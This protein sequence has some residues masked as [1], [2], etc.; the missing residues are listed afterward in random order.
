MNRKEKDR[1]TRK[2]VKNLEK[3][4]QFMQEQQTQ[5]LAFLQQ[6]ASL[7]KAKVGKK[8]K[9]PS[10]DATVQQQNNDDNSAILQSDDNESKEN[11]NSPFNSSDDGSE[12]EQFD[13]QREDSPDEKEPKGNRSAEVELEKRKLEA[14]AEVARKMKK[15]KKRAEE[16]EFS[17]TDEDMSE[18][19]GESESEKTIMSPTGK[20]RTAL[21]GREQTLQVQIAAG[22][23]QNFHPF[24]KGV[25]LTIQKISEL[26]EKVGRLQGQTLS[27]NQRR[28]LFPI[29]LQESM[30]SRV[31]EWLRKDKPEM[32]NILKHRAPEHLFRLKHDTFFRLL[33]ACYQPPGL[34]EASEVEYQLELEIAALPLELFGEE[35]NELDKF[36]MAMKEIG[37]SHGLKDGKDLFDMFTE[38]KAKTLLKGLSD[39]FKTDS[40]DDNQ[41]YQKLYR[42]L[43]G[44]DRPKNLESWTERALD[45]YSTCCDDIAKGNSWRTKHRQG[46]TSDAGGKQAKQ[47]NP[48]QPRKGDGNTKRSDSSDNPQPVRENC[49]I[50]N[51]HH[52]LTGGCFKKGHPD[53][54]LSRL[55]FF[56]TEK[57][58]AYQT[59]GK[60]V[61]IWGKKLSRDLKSL[62][63][64]PSQTK[65][66]VSTIS[67]VQTL[68][69]S[70]IDVDILPTSVIERTRGHLLHTMAAMP[71]AQDLKAKIQAIP[72]KLAIAQTVA[73]KRQ[74]S[75]EAE[76]VDINS[77]LLKF[78]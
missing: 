47:P 66:Q 69:T 75:V 51:G 54:N 43:T 11:Q 50:C 64:D 26:Q 14:D 60:S 4:L 21:K 20:T 36:V 8:A 28:A 56:D 35:R 5:L 72:S 67:S 63:D 59:L 16:L 61:L 42:A 41:L 68:P 71:V 38:K 13:V 30:I 40:K 74:V 76:L 49:R 31:K 6:S 70:H 62:I 46:N 9:P 33:V 10:A 78:L 73:S 58:K 55:R 57:G 19:E 44:E 77:N 29:T 2:T 12:T 23:Q 25:P 15:R 53:A 24:P 48:Q 3:Q 7:K 65:P 37:I 32:R 1:E 18:E 27:K 22:V 17:S 45:M 39:R 52:V 34:K